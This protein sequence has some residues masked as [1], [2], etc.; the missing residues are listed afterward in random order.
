LIP[1][2]KKETSQTAFVGQNIVTSRLW[3]HFDQFRI[4]TR[5]SRFSCARA[6]PSPD[7]LPLHPWMIFF[8]AFSAFNLSCGAKALAE[9]VS[10][11]GRWFRAFFVLPQ[12]LPVEERC[13]CCRDLIESESAATV[14]RC[15]SESRRESRQIDRARVSGRWSPGFHRLIPYT[16]SCRFVKVDRDGIT[17]RRLGFRLTKLQ[18]HRHNRRIAGEALIWKELIWKQSIIDWSIL[19]FK[20]IFCVRMVWNEIS[21]QHKISPIAHS[22]FQCSQCTPIDVCNI[23]CPFRERTL[24]WRTKP[25]CS[26]FFGHWNGEIYERA[27]GFVFVIGIAVKKMEI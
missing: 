1:L 5:W 20:K 9:P 21:Y 27:V 16:R 25:H 15:R 13:P 8:D 19:D 17:K 11:A 22:I 12:P 10:L 3:F 14:R 23:P 2:L 18:G 4:C 6:R 7:S 24:K 26:R